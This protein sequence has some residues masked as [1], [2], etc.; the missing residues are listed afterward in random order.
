MTFLRKK[1][2]GDKL[3]VMMQGPS[4]PLASQAQVF[5]A[6][7]PSSVYFFFIEGKDDMLFASIFLKNKYNICIVS[8]YFSKYIWQANA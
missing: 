4:L 8:L 5:W 6:R 2:I 3:V 1:I 7:M